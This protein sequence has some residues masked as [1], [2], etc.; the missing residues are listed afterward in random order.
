MKNIYYIGGSPCSGK[1]TV[2]EIL[3]EKYNLHYFKVDELLEKYI[4]KGTVL[5]KT[6]CKRVSQ[7]SPEGIW[8]REP[9]IQCEEEFQ[10]YEEIFEFIKE[11]INNIEDDRDIITEAAAYLPNLMKQAGIPSNKYIA[12]V[13]EREFQITHYKQRPWIREVL[14]GCS[15][16]KK[17]FE[18][19]M[20]RDC[21]FAEEVNRR[22]LVNGY[23]S[24]INNGEKDVAWYVK[25]IAKFFGLR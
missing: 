2:T 12:L 17:A 14:K 13:P 21:L 16:T 10:I 19:W 24:L 15:D 7:L 4:S 11:D 25:R 9:E 3:A 1:S 22:C 5:Q 20:E 6:A 18:N 23:V 8:M